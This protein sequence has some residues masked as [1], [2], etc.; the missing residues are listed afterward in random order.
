MNPFHEAIK[1]IDKAVQGRYQVT[2]YPINAVKP[3]CTVKRAWNQVGDV[4]REAMG[5]VKEREKFRKDN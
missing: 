3:R 5:M 2:R 4:L 1:N